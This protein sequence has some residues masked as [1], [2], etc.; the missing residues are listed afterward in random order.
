MKT[1]K[2][3][4]R[5]A[6]LIRTGGNGRYVSV[7]KD[8]L[9]IVPRSLDSVDAVCMVSIYATAYQGLRMLAHGNDDFSLKDKK[10]LVVGGMDSV[11][12]ALIELLKKAGAEVYA[13]APER[14]HSYI[15]QG[16]R[17]TPLPE[18]AEEWTNLIDEEMDFVFDGVCEDA[19]ESPRKVLKK[20][21]KVICFGFSSMLKEEMGAFGAPMSAHWKRL[22]IPKG[23]TL[24]LWNSFQ[25]DKT[26]YN[27][28]SD[29][30]DE[31]SRNRL[32]AG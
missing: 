23:C 5:V 22:T 19:L 1:F 29:I 26:V 32:C 25:R 21:G 17:A 12:Q 16:L 31:R 7:P 14:R 8:S 9:V 2:E 18:S 3:G 15:E 13:T 30:E 24:D 20:D 4:D 27:V 6:A 11:G 28:R 10:V